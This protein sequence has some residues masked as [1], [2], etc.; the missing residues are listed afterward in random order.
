MRRRWT[1]PVVFSATLL[2]LGGSSWTGVDRGAHATVKANTVRLAD[3]S[4]IIETNATDGDAGLQVFLDGEGWRRMTVTAP[5]G[6]RMLVIQNTGSLRTWGL[7]ELFSE[8]SEPP[9]DQAPFWKFKKRFP[10]GIYRFAGTTI[11]GKRLVGRASLT[12]DIPRAPV[13]TSPRDGQ[14]VP[15]GNVLVRWRPVTKPSGIKIVGYRVI[16]SDE[17]SPRGEGLEAELG[18]GKTRIMIPSAFFHAGRDYKVEVMAIER[19]GNQ[20]LRE[21]EFSVT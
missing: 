11:D 12:H 10:E 14:E 18:P 21:N 3:A 1:R 2:L 7:T 9:F 6:R 16:V 4:L 19:G 5:D 17:T 8:S 13:I 15:Y 20:T